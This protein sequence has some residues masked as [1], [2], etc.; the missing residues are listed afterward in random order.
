MLLLAYCCRSL[1]RNVTEF[2]LS[3]TNSSHHKFVSLQAAR[4]G[5]GEVQ[6]RILVFYMLISSVLLQNTNNLLPLRNRTSIALIG[7]FANTTEW[8]LVE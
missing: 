6:S 4:G 1:V 8:M 5:I 3:Q 7:P 2:G